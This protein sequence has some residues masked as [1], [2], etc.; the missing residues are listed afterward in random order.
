MFNGFTNDRFE[1]IQYRIRIC[2]ISD[3]HD[4]LLQNSFPVNFNT[5]EYDDQWSVDL[6]RV[7]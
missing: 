1:P 2:G 4:S 3:I 5:I 6:I 7:Q